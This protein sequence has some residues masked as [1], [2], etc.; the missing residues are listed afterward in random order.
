MIFL[1]KYLRDIW[2]SVFFKYTNRKNGYC[3]ENQRGICVFKRATRVTHKMAEAKTLVEYEDPAL[4]NDEGEPTEH[5]LS[6]GGLSFDTTRKTVRKVLS[7]IHKP[8]TVRR[9][10][11]GAPRRADVSFTT[12][13]EMNA[14]L[15][16]I[17][18]QE[19]E[20]RKVKA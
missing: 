12:D 10:V 15:E 9:Y 14:A 16:A 7:K 1:G 6:L 8:I 2:F 18:G 17:N 3:Y 13:A 4:D 5:S 20:G 19:I 11:P